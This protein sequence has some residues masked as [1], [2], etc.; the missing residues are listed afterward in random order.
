MGG[1]S[2]ALSSLLAY[3]PNSGFR[4]A[5]GRGPTSF[6]FAELIFEHSWGPPPCVLEFVLLSCIASSGYALAAELWIENSREIHR[7]TRSNQE[8]HFLLRLLSTIDREN[9]LLYRALFRDIQAAGDGPFRLRMNRVYKRDE[10]ITKLFDGLVR[11]YTHVLKLPD[12]FLSLLPSGQSRG[13]GGGGGG[14]GGGGSVGEAEPPTKRQRIT[15][16][17]SGGGQYEKTEDQW[18][19]PLGIDDPVATYF[20]ES[21]NGKVSR[22][23]WMRIKFKHHRKTPGTDDYRQTHLCFDYQVAGYCAQG[24]KC[25]L[26]HR[27]R[28]VMLALHDE[29]TTE[30]VNLVDKVVASVKR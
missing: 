30:N 14:G 16:K 17:K 15:P 8:K 26:N 6:A 10:E 29:K 11:D 7:L 13:K 19:A 9:F 18:S 22:D 27:S 21:G 28:K 5:T 24:D 4:S 25:K 1:S 12:N 3:A 2:P 20:S 23:K